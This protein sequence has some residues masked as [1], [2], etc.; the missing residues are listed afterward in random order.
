MYELASP[1]DGCVLGIAI[2]AVICYYYEQFTEFMRVLVAT[3]CP[4]LW[5]LR[6]DM[7][8]D[9]ASPLQEVY[10]SGWQNQVGQCFLTHI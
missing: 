6:S 8:E 9:A 3:G 5:V 10:R 1:D 4:S 7:L 2:L